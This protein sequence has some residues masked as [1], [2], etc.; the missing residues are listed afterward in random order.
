M[1]LES[2][3]LYYYFTAKP[4]TLDTAAQGKVEVG[5]SSAP[6][7]KNLLKRLDRFD[8]F[9]RKSQCLN[10]QGGLDYNKLYMFPDMQ[11]PVGFKTPKFS[12]YDGTGTPRHISKYLQTN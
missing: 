8:E 12:K 10:K 2:Q 1:S 11:L 9:L 7:D 5:E 6:I 3:E 4:F